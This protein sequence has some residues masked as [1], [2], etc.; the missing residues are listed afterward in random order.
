MDS[1]ARRVERI[2]M[3]RAMRADYCPRCR[4]KACAHFRATVKRSL[5]RALAEAGDH[6]RGPATG[7]SSEV[8]THN[9]GVRPDGADKQ[10]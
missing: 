4:H 2:A 5:R 6:T 3:V 7:P 8:P 10:V 1:T 9:K